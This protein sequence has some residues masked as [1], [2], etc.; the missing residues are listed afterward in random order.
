[1]HYAKENL[2]S[3]SMSLD[4]YDHRKSPAGSF[5]PRDKL[6][7]GILCN[8]CGSGCC[9]TGKRHYRRTVFSFEMVTAITSKVPW[10]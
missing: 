7:W 8:Y 2:Y 1:M 10:L 6:L 4:V 3:Y 5:A 9:H